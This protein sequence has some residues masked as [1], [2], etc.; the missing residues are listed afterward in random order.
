MKSFSS[1][2]LLV[3]LG[4][5]VCFGCASSGG[6]GTG[7]PQ[8]SPAAVQDRLQ[9]A[10][11][12]LQLGEF[13]EALLITD[14]LLNQQPK[15]REAR[16]LAAQGNMGL[17]NTR[18]QYAGQFLDDVIR[19]LR[20]ALKLDSQDPAT[21]LFLA[22]AF[23]MKGEFNKGK[24]QALIAAEQYRSTGA[25]ATM[26][27]GAILQAA[28]NEM[29]I[30]VD[31]RRQEME[32]RDFLSADT[33]RKAQAVLSRLEF[34]K[35]ILPGPAYLNSSLVFSWLG[36]PKEELNQLELGLRHAPDDADLHARFRKVWID[37]LKQPAQCVATYKN[38]LQ[39]EGGSAGM[40]FSLGIAQ[41]QLGEHHQSGGN[42]Q[43]AI[44]T[45]Q[46]AAGSFQTC[47][48]IRPNWS[49]DCQHW[50][51]LS[52]LMQAKIFIGAG[53]LTQ[54]KTR[55]LQAYKTTDRVL[56]MDPE[57]YPVIRTAQY[58]HYLSLMDRLGRAITAPRTAESM[59]AGLSF[60]EEIMQVHPRQFGWVY[61]NAAFIA[62]DL[63][64]MTMTAAAKANAEEQELATTQA[65]ALWEKSYGHY[66]TAVELSPNDA[67]IINDCA[68]MLIYH[69]HRDDQVALELCQRAIQVGKLQLSAMK[70]ETPLA[71]RQNLEEAIGDAYQ[72]Q[73]RLHRERGHAYA[74]YVELVNEALRYYPYQRREAARWLRNKDGAEP[75][76]QGA[77]L[78]DPRAAK[79][80]DI[81][82]KTK[83]LV[84][85]EDYDSALLILDR[86]AQQ[87]RGHAPFHATQGSYSLAYAKQSIAA[88]GSAGQIDGLLADA[89]LNLQR[90]VELDPTLLPPRLQLAQANYE[91]GEFAN[92]RQIAAALLSQMGKTGNLDPEILVATQTITALAAKQL[93]VAG[94][95]QGT[96]LGEELQAARNA[97]R[98]I[99]AAQGQ[100]LSE[101]LL[102]NWVNLEQ[103]A[104]ANDQAMA[105][106]QRFLQRQPNAPQAIPQAIE[107]LVNLAQETGLHSHAIATLSQRQDATSKW[108][109]GRAIFNQAD[110]LD[111]QSQATEIIQLHKQ[112]EQAFTQAMN[113]NADY[114][115]S[116]KAWIG[117]CKAQQGFCLLGL[118]EYEKAGDAFLA[119]AS[120]RPDRVNAPSGKN[121]QS[122]KQGLSRIIQHYYNQQDP[123]K[124]VQFTAKTSA[125]IP[126]DA[127]FANNHGLFARDLGAAM[128]ASGNKETAKQ[129]FSQSL[130]SY[131]RAQ[132]LEPDNLRL[133]NDVALMLIYHLHQDLDVAEASL[134]K[135]IAVGE[136]RL[137][138]DPP[139]D[140]AELA[141]LQE[142]TGD[143][144]ENLGY[145]RLTHHK[146]AAGARAAL[147]KSLTYTP[148]KERASVQ[149]LQAVEALEQTTQDPK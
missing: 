37:D 147:D 24:D 27:A 94:R 90:A 15:L 92:A 128:E 80:Q 121:Q 66:Q 87:M 55:L 26:V 18:T 3:C 82:A 63:G 117:N 71:E 130:A 129:L 73:A 102:K 136:A 44:Q 137:A 7:T 149:H 126:T 122:I 48:Q 5:L 100:Q 125:T 29:Q 69:L 41:F 107:A 75:K 78:V 46:E 135:V 30:F 19:N 140:A 38:L 99:E 59:Q 17:V 57:G 144:W 72:N 134:R 143:A 113:L 138:D 85:E 34:I 32:V 74:D 81:L 20:L 123:K 33:Q 22:D 103:W 58:E 67:R 35:N 60:W 43:K 23:L 10:R 108:Y 36:R 50:M 116:S 118:Q 106:Y 142:V 1:S 133:Q 120:Q 68:L 76:Q 64:V 141:E 14:E 146:D 88:K 25:P 52:N 13:D 42:T 11:Q 12:H 21:H 77:V 62:R 47:V 45:F 49:Q 105:I 51:A 132:G 54:A 112:A 84:Q 109:L 83:S 148:F 2:L 28:N 70:E 114:I 91:S 111:M 98:A 31:A 115:T 79:F 97:F 110:S 8:Q 65:M 86:V 53:N 56:L 4:L 6:G 104:G 101:D 61:N 16:L 96:E 119:A 124:L 95:Q 145:A 39:S 89:R 139:A 93:Y 127:D 9:E 40:H 131:Q